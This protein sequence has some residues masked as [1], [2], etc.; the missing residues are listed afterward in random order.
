MISFIRKVIS[1]KGLSIESMLKDV[2][3]NSCSSS[4]GPGP[5]GCSVR[6]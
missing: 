1:K 3:V 2:K 5:G 4:G 6:G